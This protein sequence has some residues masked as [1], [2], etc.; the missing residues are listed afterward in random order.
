MPYKLAAQQH[1]QS[2][3]YHPNV[4]PPKDYAIWDELITKLVKHLVDR[5]GIERSL[6]VVLRGMERAKPRFLDGSA[7]PEDL[8]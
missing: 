5:Y 3:W 1:L 4:S 2:F 7:A 6:E 8:L